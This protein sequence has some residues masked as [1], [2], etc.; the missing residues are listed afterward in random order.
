MS[1]E[2]EKSAK[3][4]IDLAYEEDL[5]DGTDITSETLLDRSEMGEARVIA[6][7]DGIVC[8]LK[9]VPL[10][11]QKFAMG[12]EYELLSSDGEF[13]SKDSQILR[14]SGQAI[15]LL[16]IERTIL[17][18]LGRLSGI[19]TLTHR[20]V[21]LTNAS[22]AKV[23]DTRKTTPGW[24]RLEKY[25]VKCG[26]GENHRMGLFDAVLIKDNHLAML[27]SSE[28]GWLPRVKSAFKKIRQTSPA[29]TVQIEVDN[30]EQLKSLLPLHPDIILLDNMTNA[31][32]TEA[33]RMRGDHR[34]E[35]EA[36]GGVRLSTVAEI[37]T[38]GVERISVG[39]LTHSAV[40]FD[41]GMDWIEKM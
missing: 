17:N 33:V 32:L 20:F 15:D 8:G 40:N 1:N 21:K 11:F 34:I 27:D 30:L 3:V 31:Q 39:A 19:A 29:V 26:G 28:Q 6:R 14:V 35:L 38:T 13:V 2:L 41:F 5:H 37:A 24:R 22:R 9:L 23:F 12:L 4:L 16:K 36:S 10:I 18:F 7:E 25:A